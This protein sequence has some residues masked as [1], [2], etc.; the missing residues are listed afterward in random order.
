MKPIKYDTWVKVKELI[1]PLGENKFSATAEIHEI[2]G[3]KI[4]HGLG[5]VWGETRE[6]ANS[7]MKEKIRQWV[8]VNEK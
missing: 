7:K 4:E 3:G 1:P 5:E 6:E 8:Q 2:G